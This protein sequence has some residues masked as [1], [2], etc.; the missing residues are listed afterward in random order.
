MNPFR[1]LGQG[2][3]WGEGRLLVKRLGRNLIAPTR[4]S[5]STHTSFF[6]ITIPLVASEEEDGK[7]A[8]REVG[9]DCKKLGI[10]RVDGAE[11]KGK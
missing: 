5:P 9:E 4:Q 3:G 11:S 8:R 6:P 1:F 2:G 7:T 10:I